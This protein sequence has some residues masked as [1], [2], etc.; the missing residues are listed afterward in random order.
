MFEYRYPAMKLA[1]AA[2]L[3]TIASVFL[4]GGAWARAG[5]AS[6]AAPPPQAIP[7]KTEPGPVGAEA[8]P[9]E[10]VITAQRYGDAKV[11]AETEIGE[12]E[13]ATYGADN[14]DELVKRLGPLVGG[15]DEEPIIL[16]NGE[17]VGF[18]RSILGYPAEALSRVA[19][20]RPEAAAQYGH[21]GGRR[22]VNLV[23]KKSF[24][25][26]DGNAGFEWATRGAQY[27][28]T[29]TAGQVAI[30]GP[31]RWNAQARISLDRAL[32]KSARN[33]PP[34]TG[35]IDLVGYVTGL[36]QE[37]IDPAL[38]QA[39]GETV[40][41]AA[42]PDGILSGAP[43]L[44][45]FAATANRVHPGDPRD[46]ETLR[47][48]RR[49]MSLQLGAS[50]PLG[51]FN[52]SVSVNA[53]S[54]VSIGRRGVPMASIV[55]PAGS[56]WS[57]FTGDVLLVRP[58][59]AGR[60][61]RQETHSESLGMSL[62]LSGKFGDWQ[63]SFSA[64]YARNWSNSLYDRGIDTAR[65]QELVDR[66]DPEFNPYALWGESLLVTETSRSQGENLNAR[67]NV[68]RPIVTLP[69]GPLTISVSGG[70]SRSRTENI[71]ADNSGGVITADTRKREQLNGQVSLAIPVSRRG[72]AEIAGLGDLSIDLSAGGQKATGSQAQKRLGAGVTWSP[73]SMLQLRGAFDRQ[74]VVP[75]FDQLD[76]PRI[77]TV[78]SIYDFSRQEVAEPVWITG[79]NPFLRS[80]SRQG[81]TL[82]AQVRPLGSQMLSLDFSYR[83]RSA[84]GGV[85][86]F[87]ELTPV[88]EAAF[89]ERITRDAAGRLV[90]V[91]ARAINIAHTSEA[92]L[93]SSIALRLPDPGTK[94][95]EGRAK[96][97]DPLR[98]SLTLNHSLRLKSEL[99]TREGTPLIDRLRD[100]GQSRHSVSLQSVIGNG[101]FGADANAI[102]SSAARLRNRG[103]P[104]L[105]QEYHY[106]QPVLIK[107]GLFVD[108]ED[109]FSAEKRSKILKNMRISLDVDNLLDSYRRATLGDG[110]I[111]PGYSRDE[112]D[113]LGRT[114][115]LSIRKRF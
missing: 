111:P 52:A 78:R 50:R 53:A 6:G 106:Q 65:I 12:E 77:E 22:V 31:V 30:A 72:E 43:V 42:I 47:P 17:E 66:G 90:A 4:P 101:T 88:I 107:L 18:D 76:G 99:L 32:P 28:G 91:D 13:I 105:Q 51:P 40:T 103:A 35:P 108:P 104:G 14:I 86:P 37:E 100:N 87:P 115:R 16:V 71:Q 20:L 84:T 29:L 79:G 73:F 94:P 1:R 5:Q 49:D 67:F 74:D 63:T 112:I 48:T 3:V 83:A 45:D 98:F 82:S 54:N 75:S 97:S 15:S 26:R 27:G 85:A 7:S 33:V 113:P 89:P 58:L 39:A 61:L 10:I 41:V 80:G 23:L 69:G 102:W 11:E 34:R 9:D 36:D 62:T 24:A 56:P 95:R 21:P 81:F 8:R 96:A 59:S 70:A 64:S 2:L 60:S 92:E 109:L 25:S 57:P 38:S 55:L 110:S 93:A 44:D 114:I 19:V 68:S 46:F